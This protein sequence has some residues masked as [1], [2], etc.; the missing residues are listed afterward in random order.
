MYS[1]F[2]LLFFEGNY[3][4]IINDVARVLYLIFVYFNNDDLFAR[5]MFLMM[6]RT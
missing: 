5:E 1:I 3:R 6:S 4:L 2:V